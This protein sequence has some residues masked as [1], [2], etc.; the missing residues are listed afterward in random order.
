MPRWRRACVIP[1][2]PRRLRLGAAST[3][4]LK[5]ARREGSPDRDLQRTKRDAGGGDAEREQLELVALDRLELAEGGECSSCR[6]PHATNA[7]DWE[8]NELAHDS[9]SMRRSI[10]S[11]KS[12][13]TRGRLCVEI[14]ESTP[15]HP[16][17]LMTNQ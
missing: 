16:A 1:L 10:E 9:V 11:D 13:T 8:L 12:M 2:S 6:T 4:E 15:N 5:N 3:C 17:R 14:G 7:S